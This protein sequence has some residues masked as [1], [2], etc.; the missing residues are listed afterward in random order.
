MTGVRPFYRD[1][2]L[3]VI[4]GAAL[5]LSIGAFSSATFA[6]IGPAIKVLIDSKTIEFNTEELLGIQLSNFISFFGFP[7]KVHRNIL[8][9]ILSC[10]LLVTG[11]IRAG[12]LQC[13]WLLWERLSERFAMDYRKK[14]IECLIYMNPIQRGNSTEESTI[15]SL[16]SADLRVAR[17]YI[18]HFYGSFPRELCQIIFYLIVLCCLS[19]KLFIV[20]VLGMV[21]CGLLLKQLGKKLRRRAKTLLV[22]YSETSEWVQ[23]RLL[24]V[25]TIKQYN[26]EKL[27][28]E[29]FAKINDELVKKLNRVARA[30][31]QAA[32][33]LEFIAILAFCGVIFVAIELVASHKISGSVIVSF[34]STLSILSQSAGKIGRYFNS[35]KEGDTALRR[36]DSFLNR[37]TELSLKGLWSNRATHE[38]QAAIALH[39]LSFGFDSELII[40]MNQVFHFGK[41]YALAGPS[42]SGKSSL[43]KLILGLL[44]P[45]Q[46]EITFHREL[47]LHC[48][49]SYIPQSTKPLKGPAWKTVAYPDAQFDQK[50]LADCLTQIGLRG[51]SHKMT[52]DLSGGQ[53]Q[54]LFLA[55]ALY[56]SPKIVIMD[57]GTSALDP[58]MEST[59]SGIIKSLAKKGTCIMLIAHRP[60]MIELADEIVRLGE[61]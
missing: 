40:G 45:N 52:D 49:I 35:S 19:Y 53:V 51:L 50:K 56:H 43:A 28:N 11:L 2:P 46:G 15:S 17:E 16:I 5:A 60:K 55:R 1:H 57:E 33:L 38:S 29:G 27:E 9:E 25:E 23:Q 61:Q 21:P 39:Q 8:V 26:S 6:L 44:S 41:V 3:A 58:E 31:S 22:N 18:V 7:L 12:L 59:V 48:D 4:I 37:F 42:G 24:G 34:F 47:N 54:R 36:I 10:S 30:K 32:P 20:F 13:H 14:I